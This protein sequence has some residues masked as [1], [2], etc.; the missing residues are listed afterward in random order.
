[1]KTIYKGDSRYEKVFEQMQLLDIQDVSTKQ[2]VKNGSRSSFFNSFPFK[3]NLNSYRSFI[4]FILVNNNSKVFY[5][6]KIIQ[7]YNFKMCF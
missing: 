3:F 1:M 2:Q 6:K 7:N 5:D 4:S